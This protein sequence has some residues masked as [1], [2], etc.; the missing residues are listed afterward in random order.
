MPPYA[1]AWHRYTRVRLRAL[2]SECQCAGDGGEGLDHRCGGIRSDGSCGC[3]D[4]SA[5]AQQRSL[6]GLCHG[7]RCSAQRHPLCCCDGLRSV[8]RVRHHRGRACGLLDQARRRLCAFPLRPLHLPLQ[9]RWSS[10][11]RLG[12]QGQRQEQ[13]R[14]E[15]KG[16]ESE[17]GCESK[18]CRGEDGCESK[19][20]GGEDGCES[21]SC[22]SQDGCESKGGRGQERGEGKGRFFIPHTWFRRPCSHCGREAFFILHL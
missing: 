11:R 20:G 13:D 14:R 4:R 21:K 8:V 9:A 10:A 22:R 5:H 3:A 18:S 15:G 6:A 1:A 2:A 17:D 12:R 16:F 19:G 7:L